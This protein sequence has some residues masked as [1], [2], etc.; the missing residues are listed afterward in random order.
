MRRDD[1]DRTFG[2]GAVQPA[3]AAHFKRDPPVH[4][5]GQPRVHRERRR[6]A[7]DP[8]P[9]GPLRRRAA[10]QRHVHRRGGHQLRA[11]ASSPFAVAPG[12]RIPR[13]GYNFNDVTVVATSWASSGA[14]RG[15]VDAADGPVLRRH[16]HGAYGFTGG[17]VAI[18]KQWSLEPSVSIN[19]VELPAGDFTTNAH[20]RAHRLRVLAADVRE[21]AGAVQLDRNTSSA[22]T[23][24]S[25]GNTVRAASCSSSTPTSATR[26]GQA[27]PDLRNRAFVV[28]V[29]RLFRF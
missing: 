20:P 13:G 5:P 15:T 9:D 19:D 22:A 29:N 3:A 24:A 2:V 11:A 10:E 21:R 4:L 23:S 26:P 6:P 25:A 14:C 12:V 17:R 1:F 16:D 28:K 8:Q 7:R 27:I 18:L